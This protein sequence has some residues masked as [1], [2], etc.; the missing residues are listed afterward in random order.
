MYH[1]PI[2]PAQSCLDSAFGIL[3]KRDRRD[4]V[5]ILEHFQKKGDKQEMMKS[6]QGV[7]FAA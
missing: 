5:T 4:V 1:I 6:D 2:A 3:A 7:T